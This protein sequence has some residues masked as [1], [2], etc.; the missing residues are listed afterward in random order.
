MDTTTTTNSTAEDDN[1]EDTLKVVLENLEFATNRLC[2]QY[3]LLQESEWGQTHQLGSFRNDVTLEIL[4]KPS[5][6]RQ[7][8]GNSPELETL[9]TEVNLVAK[10]LLQNHPP[11]PKKE[12]EQCPI[13]VIRK[14]VSELQSLV[15]DAANAK[16]GKVSSD[17]SKKKKRHQPSH[18]SKIIFRESSTDSDAASSFSREDR[19]S[20]T[21]ALFQSVSTLS[22]ELLNNKEKSFRPE[23]TSSDEG[24]T[25]SSLNEEDSSNE[26]DEANDP[27]QNESSNDLE[28]A[29]LDET[30]RKSDV[31][32]RKEQSAFHGHKS[33]DPD[34]G[35]PNLISRINAGDV[36][37]TSSSDMS[38]NDASGDVSHES[39]TCIREASSNTPPETSSFAALNTGHSTERSP[40][41]SQPVNV[42]KP[43]TFTQKPPSRACSESESFHDDDSSK[44]ATC[45]QQ[46]VGTSSSISTTGRLEMGDNVRPHGRKRLIACKRQLD[47]TPIPKKAPPPPPPP[48]NEVIDLV[49]SDDEKPGATAE[50]ALEIDLTSEDEAAGEC[51]IEAADANKS[52]KEENYQYE[53]N[54]YEKVVSECRRKREKAMERSRK[55]EQSEL[56]KLDIRK[57]KKASMYDKS[58]DGAVV[59][60]TT[61]SE[62]EDRKLP[63]NTF[64]RRK[65]QPIPLVRRKV[66]SVAK[67]IPKRRERDEE[68]DDS[69]DSQEAARSLKQPHL[70]AEI[71]QELAT[72]P[73]FQGIDHAGSVKEGHGESIYCVTWSKDFHATTDE[74]LDAGS[75][76]A[77]VM[78]RYLASCAGKYITLY[79]V[80]LIDGPMGVTSGPFTM[81]QSYCDTDLNEDYY[82]CTFGGRCSPLKES[83]SGS[84]S[85]SSST[86]PL[87]PQL[88]CAGGQG[89]RITV[90]DTSR[91]ERVRSLIGHGDE[92]WD[93]KTSP[94][95]D[96]LLLS[97]SKDGSIRLWNL[98]NG[99]PIS[100]LAGHGGHRE[101]VVSIGWHASGKRIVS[102]GFDTS[103]K[104]WDVDE[105]SPLQK[106]IVQNHEAALTFTSSKVPHESKPLQVEVPIFSTTNSLHYTVVDCVQFIGDLILSKSPTKHDS[107]IELWAPIL[108]RDRNALSPAGEFV[109]LRS[110][111]YHN[112]GHIYFLRFSI[113]PLMQRLAV[114]SVT[115]KVYLWDIDSDVSKK[116]QVFQ[117]METYTVRYLEF[118]PCG[119]VL[120]GSFDDGTLRKWDVKKEKQ[121]L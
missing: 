55:K 51:K 73:D 6:S 38:A 71:S 74:M 62:M 85:P 22:D 13:D 29:A 105:G 11:S 97:A 43:E 32:E 53:M 104:I 95:D 33:T 16:S 15:R 14:R 40:R 5:A 60:L 88:L 18:H 52:T 108:S 59:P 47:H 45:Q 120:V 64:H 21:K 121:S 39:I 24:W 94:T 36:W 7:D 37:T 41:V 46:S 82:T 54:L 31:G 76:Q 63:A 84:P 68:G 119:N 56:L 20:V 58:D 28:E 109:H 48:E 35:E 101:A 25:R 118:S 98:R 3:A 99:S 83:P 49:D 86:S 113:D 9:R 12:R 34:I 19:R 66:P 23:S 102:G 116:P 110:F 57:R 44:S 115:G 61:S 30:A 27:K 91:G 75:T 65:K 26:R 10:L 93:L 80:N 17:N 114:G 4:G 72:K 106:A 112:G 103:V 89:H 79:Q 96:W 100:M 69:D 117:T 8:F 1:E 77:V 42:E 50:T 81:K 92:V 107:V 70:F 111:H 87:M 67:G 78:A 90:I 2:R